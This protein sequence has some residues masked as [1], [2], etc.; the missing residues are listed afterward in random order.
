MTR[1]MAQLHQS[2]R[3]LDEVALVSISVNPEYDSPDILKQYAQKH[4]ADTRKWYFLTGS[5]E[6]IQNLAVHS[7][8]I[9]SLEEP[10]FH[11][12]RFVLVDRKARIRGY[13]DGT[14]K[15]GIERLFKDAASL[16]KERW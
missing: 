3:L 12:G 8:K 2:F 10:I 6:D 14:Q 7:F 13:Y 1:H 11:S 4:K 5:Q 16:V 9:G 15:E